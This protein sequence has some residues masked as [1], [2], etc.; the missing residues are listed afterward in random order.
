MGSPWVPAGTRVRTGGRRSRRRP[1]V[2]LAAAAALVALVA[3]ALRPGVGLGGV[4]ALAFLAARVL[5]WA[6]LRAWRRVRHGSPRDPRRR[7]RASLGRRA[8]AV[9]TTA[10]IFTLVLAMS[11]Y[12][13]AVTRRSNSSLAIR[14]VEWLRDNGGAS[15]V[16]Q[17]ETFFYSIDAPSKGGP[18]LVRLP[19]VG[20]RGAAAGELR[21]MSRDRPPTVRPVMHPRLA[22][23]GVWHATQARFAGLAVP[24]LLVTTY[25]PDPSYPRVVAG[26]AWINS[27]RATVSLY[28]G[29]QEP[30]VAG[31]GPNE[32]PFAARGSLLATFNSGFR[33]KDGGGGYFVH[34]RLFEP[35]EPGVAT[36][37]RLANGR[38]D[39]RTWNGGVRPGPGVTFARQNLPLIVDH[40][41]PNP[42]LDNGPAWGVAVGGSVMVW[43]SGLGVDRRGNLIYA[44]APDQTVRGLARILIHGGAVRAMELDINSYWVTLNSYRKTG[45]RGARKLL[46]GM[47][48]PA[49]R[50]LS[51]DDRDFFAVSTR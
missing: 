21:R 3:L 37:V 2:E 1:S 19:S 14:S 38:M 47:T 35:M 15:L 41:R 6:A 49:L 46:A 10:A 24:P 51:P 31:G 5:W 9:A 12:V 13:G 22:G 26:L 36:V 7:L 48:R 33:H 18:A 40:G 4:M 20:V 16:S 45:G 8:M 42:N 17:I 23:E 28:S 25:R 50:Y 27:R 34:G 39:V 11:S 44:A 32:V 43:R 30:P 29:I